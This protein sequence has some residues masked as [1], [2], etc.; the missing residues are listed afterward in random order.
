MPGKFVR[1]ILEEG[2]NEKALLVPQLGV[3]RDRKKLI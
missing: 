1:A 2:V 3:S